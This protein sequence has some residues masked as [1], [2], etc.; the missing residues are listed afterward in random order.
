MPTAKSNDPNAKI[1]VNVPVVT[2]GLY[3]ALGLV[4]V[5]GLWSSVRPTL[6]S[7]RTPRP[8]ARRGW[9]PL[10]PVHRGGF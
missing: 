5:T 8:P 3:C 1:A 2:P 10:P 9:K 7:W 6:Q 4:E